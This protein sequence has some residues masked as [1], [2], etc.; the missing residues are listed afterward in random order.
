MDELFFVG[1][2]LIYAFDFTPEGFLLCNGALYSASEYP[3]LFQLIKGTYGGDGINNFQVPNLLGT[4]PYPYMKYYI[5][6]NGVYPIA[7]GQ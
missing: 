7:E 1:D 4:E 2:V 6:S 3:N 5:A